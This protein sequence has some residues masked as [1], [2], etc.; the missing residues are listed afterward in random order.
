MKRI[1]GALIV[2]LSIVFS[3]CKGK[4]HDVIKIA[5]ILPMTGNGVEITTSVK[6]ALILCVDNWNKT[7]IDGKKIELN[8]YDSYGEAK[9]GHTIANKI[10]AMSKVDIA[11]ISFS[12]VVLSAQPIFEK[13]KTIQLC[14][15]ATDRLFMM[16]PRYTLRDYYSPSYLCQFLINN[17]SSV[18]NSKE[19]TLIYTNQDFGISYEK[20]LSSLSKSN[21]VGFVLKRSIVIDENESSFRNVLT[22]ANIND[23]EVVFIAARNQALGRIVKQMRELGYKGSIISDMQLNGTD[24]L[25]IIGSLKE[26]LFYISIKETESAVILKNEYEMKYKSKMEDIALYTYNGL[27]LILKAMN[28]LKT[29]NSDTVMHKINGMSFGDSFLGD[30]R[31]VENEITVGFEIRKID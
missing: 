30:T 3:G 5:A 10:T 13:C 20:E 14:I 21:S 9:N 18:Y 25:N 8:F 29:T 19:L 1:I 4:D 24:A 16:S 31:V 17:M 2:V 26:N 27:D 23:N 6:D 15:A 28:E 12:S 11:V 7:G 22:K